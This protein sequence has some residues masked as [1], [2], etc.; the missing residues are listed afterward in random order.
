MLFLRLRDLKTLGFGLSDSFSLS[1][2]F[3]FR[4][5][6]SGFSTFLAVEMVAVGLGSDALA[7]VPDVKLK[8]F[9]NQ[10]LTKLGRL[11][12]LLRIY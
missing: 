8:S 3:R 4:P 5:P 7:A 1:D 12:L 10:N 9:Q 2:S 11:F 6:F